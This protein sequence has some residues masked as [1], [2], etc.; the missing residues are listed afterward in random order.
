MPYRTQMLILHCGHVILKCDLSQN[1]TSDPVKNIKFLVAISK[2]HTSSHAVVIERGWYTNPKMPVHYR[3]S[4]KIE[5]EY[6]F[7]TECNI[8]CDIRETFLN[9]L[10]DRNQNYA[11]INQREQFVY[12]FTN[13]DNMSLTW[14]GIFI[15]K[16]FQRWNSFFCTF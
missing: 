11:T 2:L 16:S 3:L 6:H 12:I 4:Q 15:Y 14:L 13:D 1:P 8:N 10:K 5:D 9:K 7:V